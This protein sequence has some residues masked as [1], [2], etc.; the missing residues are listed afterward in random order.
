MFRIQVI[1]TVFLY[2]LRITSVYVVTIEVFLKKRSE[3]L[4][5]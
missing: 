4:I 3:G 5:L 2:G 1:M